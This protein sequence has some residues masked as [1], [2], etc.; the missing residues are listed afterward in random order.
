MKYY[1]SKRKKS[2]FFGLLFVFIGIVVGVF[3]VASSDRYLSLIKADDKVLF[4]FINGKAVFS[5]QF[6]RLLSKF[7]VPLVVLFLCNLS[8][9]T[10]FLSFLFLLYNGV[11]FFMSS[12]AVIVEF[13]FA[14]V[15]V[16]ILLFL[17]VNVMLFAEMIFFNEVCCSRCQLASK[18]KRFSFGFDEAFWLKLFLAI[19]AALVVSLFVTIIYLI[20]LKN[21]IFMIF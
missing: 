18:Y 19:M 3:I 20:V 17:P 10:S 1:L 13:G 2:Y 4:D 7:V 11:M 21:H 6:F 8:R 12:Y 14:G 15:L 9:F 16:F 5:K